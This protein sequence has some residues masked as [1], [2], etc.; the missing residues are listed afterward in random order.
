[1]MICDS[2]LPMTAYWKECRKR[3]FNV[4]GANCS[5][6]WHSKMAGES[7]IM[8]HQIRLA[9][10]SAW[11]DCDLKSRSEVSDRMRLVI[12]FHLSLLVVCSLSLFLSFSLLRNGQKKKNHRLT[13]NLAHMLTFLLSLSLF[14]SRVKALVCRRGIQRGKERKRAWQNRFTFSLRQWDQTGPHSGKSFLS[15]AEVVVI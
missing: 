9:R 2:F 10:A 6:R 11:Y 7:E 3:S 8:L 4:A 5:S 12:L 14:L 1:M 13:E 15:C